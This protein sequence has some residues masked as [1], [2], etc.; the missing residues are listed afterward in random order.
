[1]KEEAPNPF[2]CFMALLPMQLSQLYASLKCYEMTLSDTE[3]SVLAMSVTG[4]WQYKI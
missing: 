2:V 3:L 4:V 1:M